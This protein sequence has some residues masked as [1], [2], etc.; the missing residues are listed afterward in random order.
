MQLIVRPDPLESCR[1]P[2]VCFW[3]YCWRKGST[4]SAAPT[5][6]ALRLL[7][8]GRGQMRF[9]F[10]DERY[11]LSEAGSCVDAASADSEIRVCSKNIINLERRRDSNPRPQPGRLCSLR[12]DF[13]ARGYRGRGAHTTAPGSRAVKVTSDCN[14]AAE[15][16][17]SWVSRR[18]RAK[19]LLEKSWRCRPALGEICRITY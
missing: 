4:T 18:S 3:A 16:Q 5:V 13:G 12:A 1:S 10:C 15:G 19:R 9:K 11:V 6:G 8:H 2:F 7:P 14:R 17:Q